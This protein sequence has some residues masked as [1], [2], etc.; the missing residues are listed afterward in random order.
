M[1]DFRFIKQIWIEESVINFEVSKRV[2]KAAY[3]YNIPVDVIPDA[4]T[5]SATLR[6]SGPLLSKDTLLIDFYKGNFI[7][8]CPGSDGVVCCNYYVLNTGV[9][10]LYDCHYCFLQSFLTEP[11]QTVHANTDDLLSQVDRRIENRKQVFRIGT[12]EY[13]DSLV[14][15]PL[16]GYSEIL[17]Q[18][19]AKKS[20]AVLEL[21]TKS[22]EV[23]TLLQLD[24]QKKT[25]IAWSLNPQ[26]V[27]DEIEEGTAS[28][29]ERIEAAKLASDAG[30]PLAFHFDP[31]IYYEGCEKDY[32]EVLT[33]LFD[34]I[35]EKSIVWISLGTFRYSS[36]LKE[37][38]QSRFVDDT[39]TRKEMIQGAD[40]KFR[41]FKNHRANLYQ[42]MLSF[43]KKK[44][45]YTYLCMETSRMWEHIYGMQV[46]G[47][48]T[49]DAG[50]IKSVYEKTGIR[51][52]I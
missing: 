25:L 36:G 10:C 34:S 13:S 29:R 31:M 9:N 18:H 24:H 37:I 22:K 47:P 39:L 30:Y 33:L 11:L 5:I 26:K 16:T 1:R 23:G 48:K 51:K 45:V 3:V 17:I 21:K 42:N 28:L 50:F 44:E 41:Y 35:H 12:G 40:K 46:S 38:I 32:I 8:S 19:F 43:L 49:L 2:Q 14:L 6:R 15:E 7:S 27:I 4:R 20:N 52:I